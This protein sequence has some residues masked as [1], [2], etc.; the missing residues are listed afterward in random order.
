M[1]GAESPTMSKDA[2]QKRLQLDGRDVGSW[3]QLLRLEYVEIKRDGRTADLKK[4]QQKFTVAFA[5]IGGGDARKTQ[6]FADLQVDE[7]RVIM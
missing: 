5:S 6:H 1:A 7:A 3:W 2:L 4:L